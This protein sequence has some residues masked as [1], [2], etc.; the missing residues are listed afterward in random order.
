VV[1]DEIR[2][3]AHFEGSLLLKPAAVPD[4]DTAVGNREM[5]GIFRL[6]VSDGTLCNK[7]K[8]SRVVAEGWLFCCAS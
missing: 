6:E 8:L 7:L 3:S 2:N 4:G 1:I 5:A